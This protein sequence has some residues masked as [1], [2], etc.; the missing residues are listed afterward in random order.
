MAIYTALNAAVS[1][2]IEPF[3]DRIDAPRER[4]LWRRRMEAWKYGS[5]ADYS[6]PDTDDIT[7]N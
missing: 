1:P 7:I 2:V 6:L 3:V 4:F 5:G